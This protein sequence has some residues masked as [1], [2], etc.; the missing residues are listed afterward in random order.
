VTEPIKIVLA[1]DHTL[2]REGLKRVLAQERDLLVT[3]ETS[4]PEEVGPAVAEGNADILLL[5]LKMSGREA[6][7]TLLQL[8][9]NHPDSR[10]FLLTV[11]DNK[12]GIL[13]AP[14]PERVATC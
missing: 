1:D 5:E 3:A 11:S 12:T 4:R 2:F 6:V 13:I 9:E 7:Q 10:P 14:R 8:K